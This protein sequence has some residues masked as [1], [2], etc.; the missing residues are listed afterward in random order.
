MGNVAVIR[1]WYL[2]LSE[3]F[4]YEELIN[5][6]EHKAVICTKKTMNLNHFPFHPIYTFKDDS[7]LLKII[8]K[9]QV[10]LVHARF[11]TTG[12]EFLWL[13]E[14]Y[15]IPL[16]T[17]FHGFD[18]PGN[19]KNQ[20]RYKGRL[21]SLF[22]KGDLFTVPSEHMKKI[23]VQHG[24]PRKKVIVHYSGINLEKFPFIERRMP[25][26][27]SPLI[28]LSVG[29][30]T[31]KKGIQ[32]LLKAF[33]YLSPKYPNLQLYIVG[34][35]PLEHRLLQLTTELKIEQKVRFFGALSHEQTA[36]LMSEAHLFCL[37]SVTTKE[38]NVEGIPNAIKEAMASGLPVVSTIHGGI[39][40]IVKHGTTGYLVPQRNVSRLVNAL[41]LVLE[42]PEQWKTMGYEGRRI[43]EQKFNRN[44]QV[45]KLE[46]IYHQLIKGRH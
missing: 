19:R 1:S 22:G 32:Y 21:K 7:A 30:L 45:P 43:I 17:S 28:L 18:S 34:A 31:E 13:K 42:H 16:L 25:A 12:A 36:Q 44:L 23:L 37:P 3:T 5:L 14:K 15:K 41:K 4:I 6:K 20:T 24:C 8:K 9:E 27:S 26:P 40:E 38:G 11:G 10:Q 2:P 33:S 39:P 29:R 46:K 35:G